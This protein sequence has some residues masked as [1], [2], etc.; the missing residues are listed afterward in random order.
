MLRK[1]KFILW[2]TTFIVAVVVVVLSVVLGIRMVFGE[3]LGF[4]DDLAILFLVGGAWTLASSACLAAFALE[5]MAGDEKSMS[6]LANR[7]AEATEK[8]A[9]RTRKA[10]SRDP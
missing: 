9:D 2:L 3:M 7:L 1:I 8:V 10:A 5:K 6:V 4:W